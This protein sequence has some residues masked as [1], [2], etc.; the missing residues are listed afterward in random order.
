M[1]KS[2]RKIPFCGEHLGSHVPGTLADISEERHRLEALQSLDILDT[3]EEPEFDE[4]IKLASEICDTP[5]SLISLIDKDRQW[6]KA[7]LGVSVKETPRDISFCTHAIQQSDLFLVENASTDP[8]FSENPLV[9]GEMGIRFYAGVPLHAPNGYAIGS[10][11]VIDTVPRILTESQKNALLILGRQVKARMELRQKQKLLEKAIEE[12]LKL[13]ATLRDRNALFS[14]FMNNGPF[15]SFIKNVEGQFVYYNERWRTRFKASGDEFLGKTMFDLMSPTIAS[16]LRGHDLEI[17]QGGVP[18]EIAESLEDAEHKI[19]HW[20]SYKFPFQSESGEQHL[21]GMSID[22]TQELCRKV[23]LERIR[24]E[25]LEL[26]RS[27]E[28]S[29]LMMQ[30]FVNSNP[31]ICF[32]KSEEGRYLSY[33]SRFQKFYGVGPQ[34]WIGKSDHEIRTREIADLF[35]AQDLAVFDQDAVM[36]SLVCIPNVEGEFVWSKTFKF[37]ITTADGSRILAGV[38]VDVTREMEKEKA[39]SEANFQLE[40][41]A[42]TDVLTGLSN[43]RVFEDR[44]AIEFESALRSQRAFSLIVMDIDNFKRRNDTYGH[45]AGDSALRHLGRVLLET[46]RQGDVAARIGG[47]EFAILL[48]DTDTSGAALLAERIRVLLGQF[49]SNVS[50]LTVSTGIA[51]LDP[52]QPQ[53]IQNWERLI[54]CADSAMYQAKR[55]GKDRFVIHE[56][57]ELSARDSFASAGQIP[58]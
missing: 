29:Q 3:P 58:K 54:F 36:E 10:L 9:T 46:I 41:L 28:A 8:R 25:K 37:P 23:E 12:N 18:V 20:K 57:T 33:N 15:V 35:R 26:A 19:T 51:A 50:R 13:L 56:P 55:S 45:A 47:E 34:T 4:L 31:N 21:A 49:D 17:L 24:L 5:V 44:I 42:T 14:A 16:E 22:V 7:A 48:P 40:R 1:P 53:W 2:L 30:T 11:C 32:F 27:L 39:L 6:F 43:R 38:A 52:R